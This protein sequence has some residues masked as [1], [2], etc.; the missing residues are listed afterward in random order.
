MEAE[1]ERSQEK[2]QKR[3]PRQDSVQRAGSGDGQL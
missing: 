3:W 1:R 2:S